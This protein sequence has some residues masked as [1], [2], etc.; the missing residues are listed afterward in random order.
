MSLPF[1]AGPFRVVPYALGEAAHWHEDQNAVDVDRL[2]GQAGVRASIPMWR[3]DPT[4][5]SELFNVNGI[6]HKVVFE[7][8][9]FF[10]DAN[11]DLGRLAL[12]DQLDDDAI[13]AFRRRFFFDTFGGNARW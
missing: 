1:N 13:E 6:A 4:I 10:A 9:F 11:E 3:A 2:Y 8:D 12:Y 5:Q 7:T